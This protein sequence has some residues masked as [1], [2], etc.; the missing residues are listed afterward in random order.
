MHE[1]LNDAKSKL[2]SSLDSLETAIEKK[3]AQ[4]ESNF[5]IEVDKLNSQLEQENE[6]KLLIEKKY[7]ELELSYN[8]LQL[9]SK[10]TIK[11][12][13]DSID[14]IEEILKSESLK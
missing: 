10:E 3:I 5:Q 8:N 1:K 11:E 14:A 13:S 12:I 7:N 9:L 4:I 6:Q 2:L